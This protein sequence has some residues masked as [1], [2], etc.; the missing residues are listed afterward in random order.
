MNY[1]QEG[2]KTGFHKVAFQRRSLA[3]GGRRQTFPFL[4][5]SSFKKSNFVEYLSEIKISP[6]V[7][8]YVI[9]F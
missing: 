7:S 2:R 1:R 5:F 3:V 8:H 4:N 9:A 6:T